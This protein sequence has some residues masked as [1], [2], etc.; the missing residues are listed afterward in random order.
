[1]RRAAL[2]LA[3][4]AVLLAALATGGS[5]PRLAAADELKPNDNLVTD[6]VPPIP[7]DLARDVQRYTDSR[8]ATLLDWHPTAREILVGTRFAATTQV[9]HVRFPGGARTQ[10]TFFPEGVAAAKFQPTKGD[11]FVFSRDVGG[12]ERFQ[13]FR[14]DLATGAVTLLTD[15]KS[16]NSP[17][18]WSPAGDRLAYTSTRRN[19]R[20]NDLYLIDPAEPKSD[21]MLAELGVGWFVTDW[22]KDG[23]RLLAIEYVSINE[24][25]LWLIDAKTGEKAAITPKGGG[26][27]VAYHGGRF[28]PDGKGVW[29]ATDR[30][31][32]FARLARIDLA[33]KEH[34]VFTDDIPWDVDDFDV[35]PDGSTVAFVTNEDGV[36]TLRLLDASTGKERPRPQL[37]PGSVLGVQWH[38]AGKDLAFQL[39]SARH[40]ADV[41]SLDVAGGKVERWTA[42]ETGG[43]NTS[44]FV[45]PELVKWKSFDGRAISG[46]LYRPPASFSGKRPVIVNIHGGPEGQFRPMYLGAMNYYLNE[47]G[48]AVLF[49]NVRGS[50][51]YGKT[52]LQLDNGLKREDS[53]KDVAALF[54]WI[55]GRPDLDAE[56]VMVTGGSYG[57]HMTLAVATYYPDRIRCAVDV[58]GISNLRTCLEN[59]EPYRRDLRRAE[60]GD[61]RDPKVREF[62]ERTAP[63]NNVAKITRPLFVI[64]GQNDPRVPASEAEQMVK[65]LK[66]RGT[67]VWYLVAKDEGHGF[68]KKPNV[69]YQAAA[70]AAF[71]KRYLLGD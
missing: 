66:K 64:Q 52:F 63:V 14:Y 17:G 36:G 55:K 57:G 25:Y 65:A 47:L 7:L 5:R 26:E 60:Y 44:R 23:A 13:N 2:P 39:V 29:T 30:G 9:H 42:S 3:L 53:Y 68:R 59:T 12:N 46:F 32:E 10:L 22:S 24:T 8:S 51:G 43:L 19:G 61:E 27:K 62:M 15:G 1:V 56:R 71:V 33:T 69:E 49:P 67:P 11:Y 20:D 16:R 40:P 54:D 6:G 35:S 50:S 28:A 70:T 34:T 41:Y 58:V 18:V 38:R 48:V 37:P 4:A 31:S 45:E 21:R